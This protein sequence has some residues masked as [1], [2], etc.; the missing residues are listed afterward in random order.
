MGN[1]K[2]V[3]S[4]RAERGVLQ[5]AVKSKGKETISVGL[6]VKG[7]IAPS[8]GFV[9]TIFLLGLGGIL[10]WVLMGAQR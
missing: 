10:S 1:G 8:G 7:K 3:F 6:E 4:G 5:K 2:P 9:R